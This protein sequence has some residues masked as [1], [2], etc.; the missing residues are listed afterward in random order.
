MG[1][2]TFATATT[3]GY[4]NTDFA[5]FKHTVPKCVLAEVPVVTQPYAKQF[6]AVITALQFKY[7]DPC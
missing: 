2:P 4:Y 3:Q 1:A 5:A 6:H 7:T